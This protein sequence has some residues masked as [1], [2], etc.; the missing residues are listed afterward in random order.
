MCGFVCTNDKN[1]DVQQLLDKGQHRG[2]D[3]TGINIVDGISFGHNRLS[4][5]DVDS[6]SNQPLLKDDLVIIFNGEI[7]NFRELKNELAQ[8]HGTT[9]HTE[10]DTEV[11]VELYRVYGSQMLSR[12]NGMY[13][14]V[15]YDK[16]Q[17][18]IFAAVDRL[19]VKPMY[20]KII[21]DSFLFAS[22]SWGMSNKISRENATSFL[23]YS[24]LPPPLTIFEDVF[25]LRPGSA[26][27]IN[28][29]SGEHTEYVYWDPTDYNSEN[30]LDYN[31]FKNLLIDSVRLRLESDVPVCAFLSGGV[32]SSLL[33]SILSKE[34]NVDL[35][36]FTIG[37]DDKDLDEAEQAGII[38]E[39][40]SLDHEVVRFSKNEVL[41]KFDWCM[42]HLDEPL[43]DSSLLPTT[44]VCEVASKN[45]KVAL[46]A[47]G[48]D[49][50]SMGYPKYFGVKKSLIRR[51]RLKFLKLFP[52]QALL[53]IAKV[54]FQERYRFDLYL[55][56]IINSE[57]DSEESM[58]RHLSRKISVSKERR[59]FSSSFN[60]Y[61]VSGSNQSISDLRNYLPGDILR[62]V[63]KASMSVS[64]E[65]REPFLDYRLFE[66]FLSL[67]EDEKATIN[68]QKRPLK[69]LLSEYISR[70]IWDRPKKGFS[71]PINDW[72]RT[73]LKDRLL[74]A[75]NLC[76]NSDILVAK[77]ADELLTE[78]NNGNDSD[79]DFFWNVLILGEFL[80]RRKHT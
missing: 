67:K 46:S 13:S 43:G 73:V 24:Y 51:R 12:I 14:F 45:F 61:T 58:L 42:E 32:D 59:L 15:I 20:Y 33:A 48:G 44:L 11:L 2:P 8:D 72:L 38:A 35:K 55:E 3:Y 22:E 62:K 65:A 41:E 39:K 74:N 1:F 40:L 18:R 66:M 63:D 29:S 10:G 19:G 54:L 26:M 7:Y 23:V 49:E 17:C 25:K 30:E 28:L 77:S 56:S 57:L 76:V 4:I 6:R 53:L 69:K 34:L 9:F 71:V 75:V 31:K 16:S 21:G 78:F 37:V 36:Y 27:E 52:K 50:L 79:G 60:G 68:E 80:S 70:D 5:L 64:L 47:D